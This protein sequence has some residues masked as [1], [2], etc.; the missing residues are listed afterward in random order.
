MMFFRPSR[1]VSMF[2]TVL[3]LSFF[4]TQTA[5]AETKGGDLEINTQFQFI[6]TST[7]DLDDD[8]NSASLVARFGYFFNPAINA[9]ATLGYIAT[10]TGDTDVDVFTFEARSNYHFLT[11]GKVIPYL[12][13]SL[14]VYYQ[15]IDAGAFDESDTGI[16]FGG[17]LGLKSFLTETVAITTEYSIRRTAGL[18]FDST[19]NAV[20]VGIS[21][22]WR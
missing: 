11:S 2:I 9:E 8:T 10:S 14:G 16:V 5:G 15:G 17:Q 13:P 22:F 3:F 18:E 4:L 20:L 7:D 1:L 19:I 6:N 12:G 21:Y